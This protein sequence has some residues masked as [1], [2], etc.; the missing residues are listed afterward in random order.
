[1]LEAFGPAALLALALQVEADRPGR[2]LADGLEQLGLGDVEVVV[3]DLG[4]DLFE[5]GVA[6]D[7]VLDRVRRAAERHGG[8]QPD[9]A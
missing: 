9:P 3:L 8:A 2:A 4:L 5:L 7:H 6:V 1:V